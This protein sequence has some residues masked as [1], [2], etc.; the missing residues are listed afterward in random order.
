MYRKQKIK[1]PEMIYPH[2]SQKPKEAPQFI[3]QRSCIGPYFINFGLQ[4]NRLQ[5]NSKNMEV[6]YLQTL[7]LELINAQFRWR[8][9]NK[10]EQKNT[11]EKISDQMTILD[12]WWSQI[13]KEKRK[14]VPLDDFRQFLRKIQVIGRDSEIYRLLKQT[15]PT[16]VVTE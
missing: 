12:D 10:I 14:F 4:P 8:E 3:E 7:V 15:I 9:V 11:N 2:F 13:D 1:V 5:E 16:E 6:V